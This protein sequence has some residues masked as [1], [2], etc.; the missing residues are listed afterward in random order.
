M[1]IMLIHLCSMEEFSFLFDL[2]DGTHTNDGILVLR[3]PQENY[4]PLFYSIFIRF[5]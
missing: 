4:S 3:D 5:P 1:W 2:V